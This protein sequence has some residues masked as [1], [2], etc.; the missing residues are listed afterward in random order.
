MDALDLE[1]EF[2]AKKRNIAKKSTSVLRLH[3][4][5]TMMNL[6]G[7]LKRLF[8]SDDHMCIQNDEFKSF[9]SIPKK[10]IINTIKN[11]LEEVGT[12]DTVILV[13]GFSGSTY[14]RE[15]IKNQSAF[16]KIKFVC[17]HDPGVVVLQGAVLFGYNPRAV[18][19]RIP[20]YTYGIKGLK[21]FDEKIHPRSKHC[22]IDGEE[23]C[24]DVFHTLVCEGE[25][26]QYDEVKTFSGNSNHRSPQ[27]KNISTRIE[28]YQAKNVAK[29]KLMFVTD[30]GFTSIG[31]IS[32]K[33][34]QDGWPDQVNYEAKFYF[35][36]THIRVEAQ[37]T[38]NKVTIKTSFE[39]D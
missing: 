29:G 11:I 19:A 25:L 34:P 35:G 28:I 21:P 12:I 2:E 22:I 5:K 14:L 23:K 30:E 7:F 32:F 13:G 33:P 15:E 20:R 26:M 27:R 18:S 38:A 37:E 8:T 39:L 4:P 17:P 9:F 1:R 6:F 16:S 3:L 10:E 24:V 31:K 36:Q